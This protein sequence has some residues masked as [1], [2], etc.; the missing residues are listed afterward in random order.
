MAQK[1]KRK[2]WLFPNNFAFSFPLFYFPIPEPWPWYTVCPISAT[3]I[4]PLLIYMFQTSCM[5]LSL[6]STLVVPWTPS[7]NFPNPHLKFEDSRCLVAQHIIW[8][9]V[10]AEHPVPWTAIQGYIIHV[11]IVHSLCDLYFMRDMNVLHP[12]LHIT[13]ILN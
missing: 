2:L 13:V 1:L 8:S 4:C 9:Q 3:L 12:S 5:F 11:H 6:K 10:L 7:P